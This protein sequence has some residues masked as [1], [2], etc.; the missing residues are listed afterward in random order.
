MHGQHSSADAGLFA[1]GV[2]RMLRQPSRLEQQCGRVLCGR[3]SGFFEKVRLEMLRPNLYSVLTAMV[4]FV[5]SHLAVYA[6]GPWPPAGP[7]Y[8]VPQHQPLIQMPRSTYQA[9]IV[10]HYVQSAPR[11]WD[12]QQPIEWFV[13][14]L[15]RRSWLK[16]EYLHWNIEGPS[17]ATIGAPVNGL[18]TPTTQFEGFDNLNGGVSVG[19]SELLSN[20]P[21]ELDDV[22]GVRGTWGLA[23][24]GGQM[25]MSFFG[26]EQRN[27]RFSTG[28]LR[29]FRSVQNPGFGNSISPNVLL[30]LETNGVSTDTGSLN[31]IVFDNSV[32]A[33]MSSQ[34][35][36]TEL[37]LLTDAV[38]PGEGFKWQWLGGFRYVNL[39]EQYAL[40]GIYDAGGTT[41]QRLTTIDSTTVNNVYGP[42]VG[43]RAAIVHRWFTVSATPRVTFGLNDYTARVTA[44]PLGDGVLTGGETEDID[45]CTITQVTLMGELHFNSRFSAYGGYDFMWLP[46][47]SRPDT[48]INY[49]STQGVGGGF[50]P[51]IGLDN[52]LKNIVVEGLNFGLMF[53]Y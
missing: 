38:V 33:S 49:D 18:L 45:F 13:G 40:R 15:T 5:G 52:E 46:R 34:I 43:G 28:N 23:L 11:L 10:D 47:V 26:T 44:N 21:L 48:N 37:A 12:E 2:A 36:G 25:E 39:D 42:Q 31:A 19:I 7:G 27:D 9:P 3:L 20:E 30:P 35:W 24:N 41:A 6:Q 53:R 22:S 29:N 51:N 17:E 8:A 4:V 16:V 14:E 1:I 50:V 32:S